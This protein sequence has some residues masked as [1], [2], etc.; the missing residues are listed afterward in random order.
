MRVKIHGGRGS[1][2]ISVSPRRIEA[3]GKN[4]WEFT[5]NKSFANWSEVQAAL[6]KERRSF[7]QIYG[8]HTTCVEVQS[9]KAEMPFFF[10]AGTGLT[11]AGTDA[12]SCLNSPLFH[13]GQGEVAFFLTHT[14]WDHI[15]GLPTIEQL[16]KIGNSFH[17]YGAH[18]KLSQR[19]G[20]LFKEEHFPVPYKVVSKNFEFHQ[21]DVGEQIDFGELKISN[22][23]Q[24][25]PGGSFAYRVDE[26]AKSLVFATDVELKHFQYHPTVQPGNN[27]YSNA[28]VLIMDAQYSPEDMVTKEGYGHSQIYTTVEFAVKEKVKNLYLFHQCPTYN[29]E[30]VDMQL[31]RAKAHLKKEFS[32]SKLN[33]EIA[34]EGATI[35]I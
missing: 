20:G 24:T 16:Y 17:F 19:I 18:K 12:E 7:H 28:D 9:D 35:D 26:G 29:D 3:I 11:S 27:I 25:H 33:I 31:E 6:S 1:H 34:I 22:T 14:H 15:I 13:T 8:G 23:A 2:P 5:K 32:S 21:L 30:M 4:I 10:D